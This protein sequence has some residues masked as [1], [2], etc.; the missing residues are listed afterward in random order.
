MRPSAARPRCA[1]ASPRT[2]SAST[3][4]SRRIERTTSLCNDELEAFWE[5]VDVLPRLRAEGRR[6]GIVT[7]KRTR[8]PLAFDQLPGSRG[9]FRRR[10]RSRGHH[11]SQAGPRP[12]CSRARVARRNAVDA[13][14]VGDFPVRQSAPQRRPV[15][16]PRRRVGRHPRPGRARTGA[17]RASFDM[18]R[19]FCGPL[20]ERVPASSARCWPRPRRRITSKT[21]RSWPMPSTIGS[22]TT[23]A[24]ENAHPELVTAD[25]PTQR[26][27][28]EPSER[29]T[30]VEHLAP[31]GSLEK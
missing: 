28:A 5:V 13:A 30:K 16:M 3:T 22:T 18:Q 31:M 24:L 2:R 7:A 15:S 26:V 27:G 19:I 12:R 29:F 8:R 17:A 14:Y 25:S 1:D 9:Q 23:R 6:L 4:S 21:S 10:H 20:T 11:P